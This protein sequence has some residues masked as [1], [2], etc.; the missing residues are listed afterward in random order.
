M[1]GGAG[2]CVFAQDAAL[3]EEFAAQ[4]QVSRAQLI[5]LLT[6]IGLSVEDAETARAPGAP[7][8][9]DELAELIVQA[10]GLPANL[11]YRLFSSPRSA[12]HMARSAEIY[13]DNPRRLAGGMPV[14]G[15]EVLSFVREPVIQALEEGADTELVLPASWWQAQSNGPW[16]EW[17][18]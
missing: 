1:F 17:S 14:S 5:E 4:E 9:A 11:G 2:L 16:T 7:V 8:R 15:T 3:L 6:A 12:L 18:C 13:P 10:A